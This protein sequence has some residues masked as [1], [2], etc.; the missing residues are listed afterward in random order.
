M[1]KEL[2][3]QV[4]YYY[5]SH[6]TEEDLM[7][8]TA[9]HS[10]LIRYLS[11][12][13]TWLFRE[14]TCAIYEN[15]NFYQT[16]NYQEY[17]VAPDLA[18][19]KG[20]PLEYVT[21]WAPGRIGVPPHVIFEILSKET[22]KKDLR[23]KPALY[24]GMGVQEYFAYDP[25]E[26]PVQRRS[27]KRLY[28][29]RLD[30]RSGQMVEM[31]P[32]AEGWL[33]SEQLDS[34][35]VPDG[36]HLRLYDRERRLRLTGE[37]AQARRAE[38]T[39]ERIEE[40]IKRFEQAIRRVEQ[41]NERAEAATK[42]AQM[43]AEEADKRAQMVAEQAIKRIEEANKRA[44]EAAKHAQLLAEKLRSLGINPDEL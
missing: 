41:A 23:E 38:E 33:W 7:G 6:P 19:I 31:I 39:N 21:S 32:N 26:P 16:L 1:A 24:A 3:N 44:E 15:L 27:T 35:L 29:W 20:V 4:A 10:L 11:A 42:H 28:G 17:P 14:Q 18:V 37:E 43:V 9:F 30:A 36:I 2:S 40:V 13:L 34:W 22:W 8:E 12:V 25:N 5:D